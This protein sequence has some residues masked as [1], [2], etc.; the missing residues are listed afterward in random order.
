MISNS[1]KKIGWSDFS[2]KGKCYLE[3]KQWWLILTY[4]INWLCIGYGYLF[5]RYRNSFALHVAHIKGSKVSLVFQA[6]LKE[7]ST[8]PNFSLLDGPFFMC[9][10]DPHG[11]GELGSLDL[12]LV[13]DLLVL[14]FLGP[15]SALSFF[16]KK[17]IKV[18]S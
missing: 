6:Q 9:G 5:N 4:V 10:L 14:D 3:S 11:K 13:E 1:L 2:S 15:S 17:K 16:L 18:F 8:F 7:Q 12:G